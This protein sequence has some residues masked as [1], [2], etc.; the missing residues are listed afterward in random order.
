MPY[1]LVAYDIGCDARR[2]RARRRLLARGYAMLQYSVYAARGGSSEAKE[3]AAMLRPLLGEGDRL[4][5]LVVPSEAMRRRIL[6]GDDPFA[7]GRRSVVT[8]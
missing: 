2:E 5:V 7:A 8:V 6:V 3:A 1:V 4:L